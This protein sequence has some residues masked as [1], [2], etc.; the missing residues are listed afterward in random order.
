MAM[1][2]RQTHPY[3]ELELSPAAYEEIKRKLT[4]AGYDRFVDGGAIY[5]H[6]LAVICMQ[7]STWPASDDVGGGP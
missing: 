4:D 2:I 7:P 5:M 1:V 6:G 3:V